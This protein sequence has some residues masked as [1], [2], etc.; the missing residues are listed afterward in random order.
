MKWAHGIIAVN[1]IIL[2]A[3]HKASIIHGTIF[4]RIEFN[5]KI[6]GH[7][8]KIQT[9]LCILGASW[10][11]VQINGEHVVTGI[12]QSAA[13]VQAI[14]CQVATMRVVAIA[15]TKRKH[16]RFLTQVT[17]EKERIAMN[18][19]IRRHRDRAVCKI[20]KTSLR[21]ASGQ[22]HIYTVLG[23]QIQPN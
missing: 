7:I 20:S 12:I 16:H 8:T 10:A 14:R 2:V 1:L 23:L 17:S 6:E 21:L 13:V 19:I 9:I 4:N 18:H 11:R 15:L 22:S 3:I 5:R